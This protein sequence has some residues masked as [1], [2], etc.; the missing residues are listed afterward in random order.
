ML[1]SKNPGIM[2]EVTPERMIDASIIKGLECPIKVFNNHWKD[3]IL[4]LLE[5]ALG[6]GMGKEWNSG[7]VLC[8][9][10]PERC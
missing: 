1:T 4:Q 2:W 3:G 8:P 6:M 9:P 5:E 7:S 10:P